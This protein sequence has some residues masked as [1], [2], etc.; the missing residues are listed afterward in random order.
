MSEAPTTSVSTDGAQPTGSADVQARSSSA[1]TTPRNERQRMGDFLREGRKAKEPART[2]SSG[3]PPV[4]ANPRGAQRDDTGRFAGAAEQEA[5]PDGKGVADAAK[6]EKEEPDVVPRKAMLERIARAEQGK[7]ELKS[8]LQSKDLELRKREVAIKLLQG[9]LQRLEQ[10]NQSGQ[11][12]DPRDGQLRQYELE[13]SAQSELQRIQGEHS[14]AIQQETEAAQLSSI[15]E[16]LQNDLGSALQKH[17]LLHDLELKAELQRV[18]RQNPNASIDQVAAELNDRKVAQYRQLNP[19]T[20]PA[21]PASARAL[22]SGAGH[23][24]PNDL[25]GIKAYISSTNQRA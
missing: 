25:K 12:L 1:N 6:G 21:A 4:P 22:P 13:R 9:E 24:L 8:Q 7:T 16:S 3:Q 10:A 11:P 5:K 18:W 2:D 15:K 23:R 17:P 20:P 14:Q 19:S